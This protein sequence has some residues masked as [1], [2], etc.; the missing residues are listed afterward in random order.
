MDN[1][2]KPQVTEDIVV[3]I[4]TGLHVRPAGDLVQAIEKLH[5]DVFIE[6]RGERVN[7]KSIMGLLTLAAERGTRVRVIAQGPDAAEA[8]ESIRRVLTDGPKLE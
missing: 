6:C 1:Q 4:A 2:S 7:A 8:V 5:A 3:S